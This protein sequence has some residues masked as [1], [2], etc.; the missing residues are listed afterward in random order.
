MRRPTKLVAAALAV[1]TLPLLA[2][3]SGA[4]PADRLLGPR[5]IAIHGHWNGRA[6]G[7]GPTGTAAIETGE[8][9][10]AGVLNGTFETTCCDGFSDSG[11][12]SYLLHH[13]DTITSKTFT[14]RDSHGVWVAD[15]IKDDLTVTVILEN[16]FYRSVFIG[17]FSGGTGIFEGA[18]GYYT[19]DGTQV[20]TPA[21][22]DPSASYFVGTIGGELRLP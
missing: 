5:V 1:A 6:P 13:Q 8:N 4:S 19:G 3:P 15:T 9:T 2:V 22:G 18:E 12:G 11:Y 21:G 7:P 10:L 20:A 17:T 16:G 14:H